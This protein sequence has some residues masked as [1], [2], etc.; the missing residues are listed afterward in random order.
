MSDDPFARITAAVARGPREVPLTTQTA[1]N[2]TESPLDCAVRVLMRERPGESWAWYRDTVMGILAD[3]RKD[4][5]QIEKRVCE[6]FDTRAN[7]PRW[8]EEY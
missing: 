3:H 2:L 8:R 5:T 7:D 6:A 4:R 1:F